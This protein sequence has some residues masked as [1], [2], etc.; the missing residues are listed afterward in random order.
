[1]FLKQLNYLKSLHLNKVVEKINDKKS[2]IIN[3]LIFIFFISFIFMI[4]YNLIYNFLHNFNRSNRAFF[5]V[6]GIRY[7]WPLFSSSINKI[8]MLGY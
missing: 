6:R 8:K 7:W 1:M 2:K 4:L 3:L 5:Y